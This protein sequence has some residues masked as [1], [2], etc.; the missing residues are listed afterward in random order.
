MLRLSKCDFVQQR[1]IVVH[2]AKGTSEPH[3]HWHGSLAKLWSGLCLITLLKYRY[4][5]SCLFPQGK[6]GL[7]APSS[8]M[9]GW[10]SKD[11]DFAWEHC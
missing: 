9:A 7:G 6:V 3:H 4:I 5:Y 1:N 2:F 10:P 11:Q 8:E